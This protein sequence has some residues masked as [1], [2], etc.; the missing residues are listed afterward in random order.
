MFQGRRKQSLV[1]GVFQKVAGRYD[2]MNDLMS[3]GLHRVWK[4][5]MVRWLL[6][7]RG[8][9]RFH[10]LDMAGGTGDVALRIVRSTHSNTKVTLCDI[11]PQ[12]RRVACKR[13]LRERMLD[14]IEIVHG[15]AQ[16]L[17]LDDNSFDAYTIALGIRNVTDPDA[18]LSEAIRVLKPGGRLSLSRVQ[19]GQI[20]TF[21]ITL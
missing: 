16:K 10:V 2:L 17:T 7:P 4:D 8:P 3:G 20:P 13:V 21:E 1:D 11:N 9:G 19:R 15:D 18:A 6:P 5:E 12:M 14:R